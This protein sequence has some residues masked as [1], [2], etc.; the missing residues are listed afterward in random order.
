MK[1]KD[2]Q[3]FSPDLLRMQEQAPAKLPRVLLLLCTALI[4]VLLIWANFAKLDIIATAEGRIVPQSFIKPVQAAEAGIVESI[5]VKDGDLVRAGQVLIRMNPQISDNDVRG[6]TNDSAI[7]E[8]AL[9]RIDDE[10]NGRKSTLRRAY[11]ADLVARVDSQYAA[12]RAAYADATAQE[13]AALE[14]ARSDLRAG[15]QVKEKLLGTLSILRKASD[16]FERL[17]NEGFVGEV[18]ANEKRRELIERE[19]DIQTQ[20]AT[21]KSLAAAVAQSDAKLVSIK[22]NYRAHLETERV[23]LM[24]QLNRTSVELSKSQIRSALLEIKAPNEGVIKDLAVSSKGAVVA[25]GTVLVTVVPKTERLQAEVLLRNEDVGFVT[26]GQQVRIKIAA[27]PFQKYGLID[28]S[29]AML[30]ADSTDPKQVQQGQAPALTYRA[31]VS[32]NK[33]FLISA[34]TQEQFPISSGMLVSAE[35]HQG[36]RTV[37]EY[38]L[39]PV[40]KVGQESARER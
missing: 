38:L 4:F 14:R 36:Q 1:L 39:S 21:L 23:E 28:G 22:S 11:P 2:G 3:D 25:A 7:K 16:S 40:Q 6:L 9:K 15:E 8:L 13:V 35:I 12:R 29:I 27:F 20:E 24:S 10:L 33:E 17:Q 26:K 34:N 30:S 32:L 18:A 5:L 19:R 31:L 37:M